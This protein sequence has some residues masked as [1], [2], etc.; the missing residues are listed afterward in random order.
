M[1]FYYSLLFITQIK[2]SYHSI[3][4]TWRML[5]RGWE[6]ARTSNFKVHMFW[7]WWRI[8]DIM[9]EQRQAEI[10]MSLGWSYWSPNSNKKRKIFRHVASSP[11]W[12]ELRYS[13]RLAMNTFPASSTLLGIHWHRTSDETKYISGYS[14]CVQTRECNQE[15]PHCNRSLKIEC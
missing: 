1:N 8:S 9:R 12:G 7:H 10:I 6:R 5:N 15:I 14:K 4:H 13:G 3:I 11:W 2:Y